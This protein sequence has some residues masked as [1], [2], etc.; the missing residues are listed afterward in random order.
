VATS[1]TSAATEPAAA[2]AVLAG[3]GLVDGQLAAVV[4][5]SV[6]GGDRGLRLLLATHLHEPES[7]AAAGVPVGNDFSRLNRPV[8]RKQLLEV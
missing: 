1:A 2:G 4:L 7:F 5:L 6:E 8:L 3:L